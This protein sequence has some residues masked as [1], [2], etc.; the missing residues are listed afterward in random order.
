MSSNN[1]YNGVGQNET[2]TAV[3]PTAADAGIAYMPDTA[4]ILNEDNWIELRLT[5]NDNNP[6]PNQQY[7]VTDPAG[8]IISGYLDGDGYAKVS[9]V[10]AGVCKVDFP[11]LGYSAVVDSCRQ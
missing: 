3:V 11:D 4:A 8:K 6:L 2:S 9:P 1:N 5:D 7:V 10:K